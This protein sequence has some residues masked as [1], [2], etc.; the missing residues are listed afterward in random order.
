[1]NMP[2]PLH[3]ENVRKLM[4]AGGQVFA[5]RGY[6]NATIRE[7][8]EVAGVNIAAVSYHFGG[9]EKLYVRLL[10]D[11]LETGERLRPTDRNENTKIRPEKR[12]RVFVH[13]LL[14]TF[15]SGREPDNDLGWLVLREC[16]DPSSI[17]YSP[18]HSY[19]DTKC[20]ELTDIVES[21]HPGCAQYLVKG[22]SAAVI[23][24]CLLFV[25]LRGPT[26]RHDFD[27]ILETRPLEDVCEFIVGFCVGGMERLG[28]NGAARP[29]AFRPHPRENEK[30][31]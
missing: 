27:A 14:A 15:N 1:M 8:C 9:K 28:V 26:G 23:W 10:R 7:I 21:L 20:A 13:H 11:F 17:A 3:E 2:Q 4:W 22:M 19:F 31:G 24:Q 16:I 29:P 25:Y 5:K 30:A 6:H 12:L 18:I